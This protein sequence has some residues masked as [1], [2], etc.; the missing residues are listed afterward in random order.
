MAIA[1]IVGFLGAIGSVA[2]VRVFGRII[3][4]FNASI[5]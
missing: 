5:R 3:A 4:G 2:A 1:M